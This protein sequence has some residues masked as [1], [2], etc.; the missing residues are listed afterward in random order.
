MKNLCLL[1]FLCAFLP[2]CDGSGGFVMW[3]NNDIDSNIR[4]EIRALNNDLLSALNDNNIEVI[5][6]L[7]S[8]TLLAKANIDWEDMVLHISGLFRME[9]YD[10][11]DEYYVK[12]ATTG[13]INTLPSGLSEDN[14]YIIR[15]KAMNN[16]MYVSLL[17]PQSETNELLITAVYG[18][19]DDGWKINIL[20]FGQYSIDK[21][22]APDYYRLARQCHEK[23]YLIDALNN[24]SLGMQCMRPAEDTFEYLKTKEINKFYEKL[25]GDV[26]SKYVFPF[27]LDKVDTKPQVFRIYPQEIDEGLF[28]MVLYLSTVNIDDTLALKKEYQQIKSVIGDYFEGI[29]KGKK[30][31]FYRAFNEMPQEDRKVDNYGFVDQITR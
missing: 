12:N 23:S 27:T 1:L 9:K 5:K 22:T 24:M 15:Y 7:M 13:V 4:K 18:K 21:K 30:Y 8:D 31:V 3:K 29:D 11:K 2:G 26:D 17:V 20:R 25:E 16:E 28:P 10:I 14:D 19:Y 6:G